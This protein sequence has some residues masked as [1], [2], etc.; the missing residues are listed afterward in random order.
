MES[1][2]THSCDIVCMIFNRPCILFNHTITLPLYVQLPMYVR[3]SYLY[4]ISQVIPV[5]C[6]A[7]CVLGER[8]M[9]WVQRTASSDK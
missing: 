2:E 4:S 9:G 3:Q 6:V 8:A 7:V 5:I 1:W